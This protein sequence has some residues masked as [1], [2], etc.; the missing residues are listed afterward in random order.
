LQGDTVLV[1]DK[2]VEIDVFDTSGSVG[3]DVTIE[4]PACPSYLGKSESVL[5]REGEQAK[6]REHVFN[7]ATMVRLDVS[8]FGKL[9]PA[10]EGYL[11]N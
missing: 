6:T 2:R 11:Q 5:F 4:D 7:G 1:N 9:Q 8:T 10:A 3:C